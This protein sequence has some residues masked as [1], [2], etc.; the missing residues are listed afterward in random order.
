MDTRLLVDSA[1]LTL[2]ARLQSLRG[3]AAQADVRAALVMTLVLRLFCSLIAAL[4]LAVL[5][6]EYAQVNTFIQ[7][8]GAQRGS[9]P[10]LVQ[11]SGPAA[12]LTQ[13]WARFDTNWYLEIALHGYARFLTTAFMPLYPAL[14]RVVGTGL[15]GHF[16]LAALLIS[17]LCTFGALLCLYRLAEK[18]SPVAGAAQW[19]LLAAALLPVS[20]FLMAGYTEALFLWLTLA[21]LLAFLEGRWGRFAV[22]AVLAVL[23][24]H[25]GLLLSVLA[26][27]AIAGALWGWLRADRTRS[28][29]L[30]VAR[31]ISKPLL[32]AL[33]G[34]LTYLAWVLVVGLV[35]HAPLPWEPLS[36]PNGWNLHFAWPG[37]GVLADLSALVHRSVPTMLGF[38]A[39]ALDAAA[40]LLAGAAI[41]AA[42]RRLPP[43]LLLYLITCWCAAVIKV[44]SA[45]LTM[46]TARYLLLLL[47]LA[48][49]PGELLARSGPALRRTWVGVGSGLL[50]F[51]LAQFVLWAWVS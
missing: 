41:V 43:G 4:P 17:T 37:L 10:F 21:A 34:P 16:L 1:R 12:Y 51:F 48:V 39:V 50:M 40:A 25:Q 22:L 32:A 46:S 29:L 49:L 33:V 15:G 9:A 8:Y 6:G 38:P 45:G 31:A 20:F 23:T 35:L 7:R 2:F 44:Q 28:A 18:L 26:L 19:T 24:R 3:W 42:A 5:P 11:M 13:P 36:A 30:S 47:P 14:I 27:P